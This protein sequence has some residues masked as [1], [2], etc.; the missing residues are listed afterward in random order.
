MSPLA[1]AAILIIIQVAVPGKGLKRPSLILTRGQ[2]LIDSLEL[3]SVCF[4]DMQH[5]IYTTPPMQEGANVK[6]HR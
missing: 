6:A 5:Q 4:G 1:E 3:M 2:S